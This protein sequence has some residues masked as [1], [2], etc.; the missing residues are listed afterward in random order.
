MLNLNTVHNEMDNMSFRSNISVMGHAQASTIAFEAVRPDDEY[1][2]GSFIENGVAHEQPKEL[3]I[4]VMLH[5]FFFTAYPLTIS[6]LAQ[7]SFNVAI[8]A[9]IGS[10]VGVDELGGA[11]LALGL[12]NAT[13]FAFG[14]GLCGAL[15]TVLSHTY[16][17][18]TSAENDRLEEIPTAN[19]MG[20]SAT[21][22]LLMYGTYAQRMS[23]ILF[24]VAFPMGFI[25]CFADVIMGWVGEKPAAVYY[26]GLWCRYAVFGIP[27]TMIY[28][29]IMRYY[30]C[31]HSTKPVSV[32]LV[33]AAA[34]NPVLQIVFIKLFGFSGSPFAWLL[35]ITSICVGLVVYLWRSGLYKKT[36]GGWDRRAYENIGSLLSIA[37]PSM[38]VMM[39]EWVVLEIN[40][41]AAG[42]AKPNELA[43][44]SITLQVFGVMWGVPS[45]VIILTCVFVGNAIGAG[46]TNQARRYAFMAVAIVFVLSVVDVI[47]VLVLNPFIP[48]MFTDDDE[49]KK[50]YQNLM[51]I[52]MPYHIVDVF[53]S[54]VMAILRGCK[55]QKIGA[56]I[57]CTAFCVFGVPLSFLLFFYFKIGVKALWIGP[58]VG[59]LFCGFPVY[60]YLLARYIKWDELEAH[61][62]NEHLHSNT[63]NQT[64]IDTDDIVVA[65]PHKG[66]PDNTIS[67]C[68]GTRDAL[69]VEDE[70]SFPH[71]GASSRE[72]ML[73]DADSNSGRRSFASSITKPVTAKQE[74]SAALRQHRV[75][76]LSLTGNEVQAAL[77][78]PQSLNNVKKETYSAS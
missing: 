59:V 14:A 29:L 28:Q 48:R 56:I 26:T 39:S 69:Q 62:D 6:V 45:G 73:S 16:G 46:Q 50:I 32:A 13:G 47:V 57:I 74:G 67:P 63:D 78:A 30:S 49:V 51:Y 10:F 66:R 64:V 77:H 53:Q 20:P 34:A 11:A 65:P 75:D 2:N 71:H 38:G 42:F 70:R 36:W 8:I 4:K 23:I 1:G 3:T 68:E 58:F 60:V 43:A 9:V 61:A 27:C 37:L 5:Q 15:E 22:G 76:P 72:E 12:V 21:P 25:L 19:A 24:V 40:A 52:V 31:Q 41:L 35:L 17:A 44:Y 54:T 18:A 7:F 33:L 55:M